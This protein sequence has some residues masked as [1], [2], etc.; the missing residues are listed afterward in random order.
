MGDHFG[1]VFVSLRVLGAV[2]LGIGRCHI[3]DRRQMG[4]CLSS[5]EKECDTEKGVTGHREKKRHRGRC[6]NGP[7]RKND[8]EKGVTGVTEKKG[9][10]QGNASL[11]HFGSRKAFAGVLSFS[12]RETTPDFLE[13][14]GV[15]KLVESNGTPR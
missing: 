7:E 11:Y 9:H 1:A 2:C 10:R 13:K 5:T 8:T 6:L 3:S 12:E 4:R 14:E 15:A